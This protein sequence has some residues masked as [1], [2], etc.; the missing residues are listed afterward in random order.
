LYKLI[1]VVGRE[2]AW[3]L[4]TSVYPDITST[5]SPFPSSLLLLTSLLPAQ[6]FPTLSVE[7]L[8]Q[9]GIAG[10]HLGVTES[11]VGKDQAD[12]F[13]ESWKVYR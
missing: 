11:I 4:L 1:S 3:S 7:D 12:F 5:L 13:E 2:E 9:K 6:T 10:T 8:M